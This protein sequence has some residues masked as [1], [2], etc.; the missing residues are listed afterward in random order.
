MTIS[1]ADPLFPQVPIILEPIL[2][3]E[4]LQNSLLRNR[5]IH[6]RKIRIESCEIGEKRYKPGK[7]FLLSYFLRLRDLESDAWYEQCLTAQLCPTGTGISEFDKCLENPSYSS[8]GIP[9]VSYISVVDMLLWSFPHDRKLVH[10][11]NLLDTDNLSTYIKKNVTGLQLRPSD[12]IESIQ[13]RIMHY[14]PEQSCMIRYSLGIVDN[15]AQNKNDA[16][17]VVV[18]GKNYADDSGLETYSVMRQLAE[19]T[20]HCAKPLSYDP[21]NKTLWQAHV[22]GLPFEW[23]LLT[24]SEK[25]SLIRKIAACIAEFHRCEVNAS[26][27]YGLTNICK[28]LKSTCM[29]ASA[30]DSVLGQSVQNAVNEILI[31]RESIDWGGDFHSP[32]H[33]DLKM[34]NFLIADDYVYLIDLDCVCLGDPLADMGSFIANL[35]LNGLRV[36]ASV[37]EI[38]E[39]VSAFVREYNVAMGGTVNSVKLNWYIAAALIHEVL[40]RSLRQQSSERLKHLDAYLAISNRYSALCCESINNA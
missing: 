21:Q 2:M 20:I 30:A 3:R 16:R 13:P 15:A 40:R 14:L 9:S 36:G 26:N 18:Y 12:F 28:D 37:V 17:E 8:V 35:Y 25:Y 10:L 34:G 19:Q 4:I 24:A 29:A 1:T 32:L 38:D 27:R 39:I 6:D 22:P 11:H 7:S 5:R 31:S 33:L 23:S